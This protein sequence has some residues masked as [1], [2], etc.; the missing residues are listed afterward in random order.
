[1]CL[2]WVHGNCQ[3]GSL[4]SRLLLVDSAGLISFQRLQE[5]IQSFH[6]SASGQAWGQKGWEYQLSAFFFMKNVENQQTSHHQFSSRS[7]TLSETAVT[8]TLQG[9][10]HSWPSSSRAQCW[11][12]SQQL[13][14]LKYLEL[15]LSISTVPL[16]YVVAVLWNCAVCNLHN[17]T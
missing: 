12:K 5:S 10:Q 4:I 1:M 8:R 16:V 11:G 6:R 13:G 3:T 2:A 14:M 15:C 9:H 17:H 7:L